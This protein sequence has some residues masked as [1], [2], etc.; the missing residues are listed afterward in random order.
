MVE[1]LTEG[2]VLNYNTCDS[3]DPITCHEYGRHTEKEVVLEVKTDFIVLFNLTYQK[4]HKV[5][6]RNMDFFLKRGLYE[7]TDEK[8]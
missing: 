6:K 2:M 7:I 1:K 4:E 3:I 8:A 5:I